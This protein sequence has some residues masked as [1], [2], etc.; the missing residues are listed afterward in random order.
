V[1]PALVIVQRN[2]QAGSVRNLDVALLDNGLLQAVDQILPEWHIEG[3]VLQR[4]EVAARR[5]SK[6]VKVS[7]AVS[8]PKLVKC[9][10]YGGLADQYREV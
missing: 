10:V 7:S 1:F 4:Q 3:M 2:P 6:V 9:A 8:I 5:L